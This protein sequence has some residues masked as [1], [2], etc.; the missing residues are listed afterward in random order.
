MLPPE[1]SEDKGDRKKDSL[2]DNVPR[3]GA[4]AR[5]VQV[6]VALLRFETE[7]HSFPAHLW[8]PACK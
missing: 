8:I 5:E 1:E 4:I 7:D 3:L 6:D 2:S